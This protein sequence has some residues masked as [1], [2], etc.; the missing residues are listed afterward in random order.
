MS[1]EHNMPLEKLYDAFEQ[2]NEYNIEEAMDDCLGRFWHFLGIKLP[3]Q[4]TKSSA[5]NTNKKTIKIQLVSASD[6]Q[7]Y[8]WTLDAA[9]LPH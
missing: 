9:P 8:L 6:G 4:Q 3:K 5:K 1:V 2:Y 7:Y